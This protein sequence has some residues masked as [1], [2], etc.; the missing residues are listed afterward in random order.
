MK[1][2]VTYVASHENPKAV[3]GVRPGMI[4]LPKDHAG[5][6]QELPVADLCG[7]SGHD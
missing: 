3:K 7:K 4:P 2:E 1:N 5:N 6:C